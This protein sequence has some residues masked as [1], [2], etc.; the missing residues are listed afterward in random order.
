MRD[1]LLS[2]L[3][4]GALIWGLLSARAATLALMWIGFQRPFDF[5]WGMWKGANAW[6]IA[7][8]VAVISN[9]GRGQL[10]PKCPPVLTAY[11][12]FVSVLSVSAMFGYLPERSWIFYQSFMIPLIFGPILTFAII[13]DLRMLNLVMWVAAGSLAL[14]GAKTGLSISI[15]GGS[16]IT[17]QINGFVGDNNV[18][19]L[20]L[21]MV[22]GMLLGLRTSLPQKPW[23]RGVLY[24][25]VVLVVLTIIYTKSRGALLSLAVILI[26]GSLLGGKPIRHLSALTIIAGLIW[27]FVPD[28]YFGRLDTLQ[29]RDTVM[30]D[31]SAMGR[32]TNWKLAWQ[33]A[34]EHPFLGIG[35]GNHI[36]Y[37]S[38]HT[39]DV[40][41]KVA[42]S[43][44]FQIL[45][46]IGFIALGLYLAIMMMTIRTLWKCW[47]E[48]RPLADRF[49]DLAW[50]RDLS[51]WMLCCYVGYAF[52]AA[53]LNMLY[54]EFPWYVAFFAAMLPPMVREEVRRREQSTAGTTSEQRVPSR[55]SRLPVKPS[56]V[57]IL[58]R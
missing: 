11:L 43:V 55:A 46:E 4:P 45:G 13:N 7:F 16:T 57:R 51:F 52:G 9:L 30:A 17:D 56:R 28:E 6:Q 36:P 18:F 49:P 5:S 15:G 26:M 54:I 39:V 48:F 32:I 19:G 29:S 44:Y 22:V 53:F 38:A 50:T 2:I 23:V 12:I 58:R 42:H 27:H 37:H 25:V 14:N 31:E 40:A 24:S 47:H 8:A 41:V 21:C 35:I 34:L 1:L 3:I 33:A 10:K 20:V